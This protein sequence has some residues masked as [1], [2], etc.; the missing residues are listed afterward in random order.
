M[1]CGQCF[2]CEY[3][4]KMAFL[5]PFEKQWIETHIRSKLKTEKLRFNGVC[6]DIITSCNFHR[7]GKCCIHEFRPIDCRLHP[8]FLRKGREVELCIDDCCPKSKQFKEDNVLIQEIKSC[9]QKI[10][11]TA[12][13]KFFSAWGMCLAG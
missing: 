7:K 10:R 9:F 11:Y 6:F 8:F 12:D 13:E 4:A 5:L 3:D 1:D 2:K